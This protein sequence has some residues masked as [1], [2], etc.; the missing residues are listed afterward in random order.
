MH[1][2]LRRYS[3][4]LSTVPE[5]PWNRPTLARGE[6]SIFLASTIENWRKLT[7]MKLLSQFGIGITL[8]YCFWAIPPSTRP[9]VYQS[10]KTLA[11]IRTCSVLCHSCCV[12]RTVETGWAIT[13][14]LRYALRVHS[15]PSSPIHHPSRR[16]NLYWNSD[17]NQVHDATCHISCR[18]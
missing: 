16:Q 9:D 10:S 8:L 18:K 14:S 17:F 12:C 1:K 2:I 3:F 6:F 11:A 7:H 5:R 15:N 13:R 4:S